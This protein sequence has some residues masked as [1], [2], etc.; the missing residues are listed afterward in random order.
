MLS[1]ISLHKE[2]WQKHSYAACCGVSDIVLFQMLKDNPNLDFV[3]LCLDNDEKG[4]QAIE[5]MTQKLNEEGIGCKP[6][7]SV[8]KDW[9]QD[10]TTPAETEESQCIQQAM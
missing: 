6:L 5:R 10:L 7:L 2:G 8:T 1:F 9:N 4:L 3:Y